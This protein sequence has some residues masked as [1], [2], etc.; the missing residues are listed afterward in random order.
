[1]KLTLN[2]TSQTKLKK[3]KQS[4]PLTPWLFMLPALLMLSTFYIYPIL[5]SFLWSVQDYLIIAGEGEFVGFDNFR[6]IFQDPL[7][8]RSLMNSLL[9]L[10]IVLPFNIFLPMI[11]ASLVNQKVKGIGFFRVVYYSPV[12]TPMV[13]A[14]LMWRMLYAESGFI[15][16]LVHFLGLYDRPTNLLMQSATALLAV[17]IITV[18]KGL[19]YYMMIYLAGMQSISD[20]VYEAASIDGANPIQKFFKITVPMLTPSVTLVSIMTIINGL[21]VFEEIALTTGGG[22]AGSTTTLVIYI[23]DKFRSLQVST[24]SAA[25]IVLLVLA[26]VGSIIQLKVNS[27]KERDLKG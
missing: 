22:P 8:R 23:F 11:I 5:Q 25:G 27:G 24:A 18:W 12:V 9:F 2:S 7:F 20:E 17:T 4:N 10:A 16:N 3:K 14:A 19:G 26:A 1:M 21:K 15:G 13:V 6:F